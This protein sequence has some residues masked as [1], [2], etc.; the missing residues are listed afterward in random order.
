MITLRHIV[1]ISV[2]VSSLHACYVFH[3]NFDINGKACCVQ[4]QYRLMWSWGVTCIYVILQIILLAKRS[5]GYYVVQVGVRGMHAQACELL[6]LCV[7]SSR[8]VSLEEVASCSACVQESLLGAYIG[9]QIVLFGIHAAVWHYLP[10]A[11]LR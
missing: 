11:Q 8:C 4:V 2:I 7:R 10:A 6:F 3:L 1:S 5:S 9:T